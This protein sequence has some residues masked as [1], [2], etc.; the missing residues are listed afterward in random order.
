MRSPRLPPNTRGP[1]Q[2]PPSRCPTPTPIP[3]HG[4]GRAIVS[5]GGFDRSSRPSLTPRPPLHKSPASG[6]RPPAR[7]CPQRPGF[8]PS[9]GAPARTRS[10]HHP[11]PGG[12]RSPPA[13]GSLIFPRAPHVC[14]RASAGLEEE[15]EAPV[16]D[17]L[18]SR[19]SLLP[20]GLPLRNRPRGPGP[21]PSSPARG[22]GKARHPLAPRTSQAV[23]LTS[24]PRPPGRGGPS[25]P[26]TRRAML[27]ARAA[28]RSSHRL[29]A[30]PRR[31]APPPPLVPPS[32]R[33][34]SS[35]RGGAAGAGRKTF[36]KPWPRLIGP[37][38]L[39]SFA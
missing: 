34:V 30:A 5:L 22:P 8:E 28:T 11:S 35:G 26:S 23:P 10:T 12:M 38:R 33:E 3:S 4:Q 39:R 6:T 20:P 18:S 2:G 17:S 24:P 14:W 36:A 32:A 25:L 21:R 16:K 31:A 13:K 37:G 19:S 29:T 9:L 15:G 7:G 1:E 27:S